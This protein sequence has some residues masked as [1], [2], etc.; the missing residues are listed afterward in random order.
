MDF[1]KLPKL[2]AIG[3]FVPIARR[4]V[5][6]SLTIPRFGFALEPKVNGVATNIEQFTGLAFPEA[7]QLNGLDD[8]LSEVV[9]IGF[10]HEGIGKYQTR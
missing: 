9:A 4:L 10:S 3:D 1:G 8:F 2:V 6:L 5:Q 7:I